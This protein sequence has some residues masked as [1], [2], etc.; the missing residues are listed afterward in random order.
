M[1]TYACQVGWD[2]SPLERAIPYGAA[3]L[4]GRRG[5]TAIYR[6]QP[7]NGEVRIEVIY[8]VG[9]AVKQRCDASGC[10]DRHCLLPFSLDACDHSLDQGDVSPENARLHGANRVIAHHPAWLLQSNPGKLRGGGM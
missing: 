6:Q 3:E 5:V 1:P 4:F 7:A 8:R 10:D 2:D 9:D